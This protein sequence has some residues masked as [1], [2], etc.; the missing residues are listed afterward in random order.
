MPTNT[1]SRYPEDPVPDDLFLSNDAECLSKHISR[2]IAE[3]RAKNGSLYPPSTQC[4]VWST[5]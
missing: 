1:T 2:F 5:A 4:I 3:T